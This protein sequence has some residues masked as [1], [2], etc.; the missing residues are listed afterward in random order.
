[1]SIR[2]SVL[3]LLSGI[4]AAAVLRADDGDKLRINKQELDRIKKQL[5]DT[6]QTIDSLNDVESEIQKTI[7]GYGERV[8]LNRKLV[9]NMEKKLKGV[10]KAQDAA[11]AVIEDTENRLRQKRAAYV[12]LLIDYYRHEKTGTDF[13]L[14]DYD[15]VMAQN[16]TVYY[17]ASISG[18]TTDEIARAGDSVKLLTQHMD[19]LQQ[20]GTDL[21][22]Q[23]RQKK[24]KINLDLTLKQKEESNLGSVRRQTDIM[25][26]RLVSLSATARQMEEIIAELE[27]NQEKRRQEHGAEERFRTGSFALSKGSLRP[28]IKGKIVSSFGWKKDKITNLSSFSPGIDI[29]PSS[30]YKNITACAPGRVVYVGTLRGY[31]KFVILEH[32]DGYYTTYAGL[33]DVGVELDDLVNTGDILGARGEGN[34]HFEIRQGREHLDPVIWLDMYGF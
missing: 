12:N 18:R 10:R 24:A 22:R 29:K 8:D 9:S 20:T 1:M 17:L 5:T 32:D 4:F 33:A 14:W 27:R 16:R 30:E 34:V 25:Q 21:D 15:R 11:A 19:S 2:W 31:D 28:P 13:D 7:S 23:R 3:F 6:R 26:D